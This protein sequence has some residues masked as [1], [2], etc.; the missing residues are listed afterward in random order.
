[1]NRQCN[2]AMGHFFSING[3]TCDYINHKKNIYIMQKQQTEIKKLNQ[4]GKKK[5]KEKN[6]TKVNRY[7]YKQTRGTIAMRGDYFFI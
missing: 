2:L 4:K 3:L 1:M 6:L 5:K 7:T